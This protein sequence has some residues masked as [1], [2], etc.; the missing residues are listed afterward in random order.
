MKCWSSVFFFHVHTKPNQ[1]EK[2]ENQREN[3]LGSTKRDPQNTTQTY[4]CTCMAHT[5]EHT[6]Q[7]YG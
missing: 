1:E 4:A 5:R 3:E 2:K 6:K 7:E